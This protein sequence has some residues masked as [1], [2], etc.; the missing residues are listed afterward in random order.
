M[1]SPPLLDSSYSP[2]QRKQ[3]YQREKW[4]QDR[5][6][7]LQIYGIFNLPVPHGDVSAQYKINNKYI[8]VTYDE[9]QAAMITEQQ[10]STCLYANGQFC[11][12]EAPF[13]ALTNQ[14]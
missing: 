4:L 2:P 14:P 8:G 12:I 3:K 11:K 10:Y 6:K 13:Q 9:M 5:A 7:Q 1:M